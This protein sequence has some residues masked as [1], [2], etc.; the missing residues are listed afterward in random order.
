MPPSH[1][2]LFRVY[3]ETGARIVLE[4][5][6]NYADPIA[7]AGE[8]MVRLSDAEE[9]GVKVAIHGT[10]YVQLTGLP[11]PRDGVTYVVALPPAILAT[12]RDD[13]LVCGPPVRGQSGPDDRLQGPQR[14]ESPSRCSPR[15]PSLPQQ[16]RPRQAL[17]AATRALPVEHLHALRSCQGAVRPGPDLQ[18]GDRPRRA[19]FRRRLDGAQLRAAHEPPHVYPDQLNSPR[20]PTTSLGIRER[21]ERAS[22]SPPRWTDA[23]RLPTSR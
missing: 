10:A 7:R 5:P 2:L 22:A 16:G 6:R 23:T 17:R 8:R 11:E 19:R 9:A 15:A 4:L 13:L 20:P 21:G 18:G 12:D 1:P 14:S 3:D